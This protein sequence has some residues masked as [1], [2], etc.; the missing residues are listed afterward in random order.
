MVTYLVRRLLVLIVTLLAAA[1]AIF[2]ILE[3]LP[4]D[5]ALVILGMEAS[6][7]TLALLRAIRVYA[8]KV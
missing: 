8:D 2:I 5:P 3:V 1:A 6:E 7:E 4:G